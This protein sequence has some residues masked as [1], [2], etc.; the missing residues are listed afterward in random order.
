MT[1]EFEGFYFGPEAVV[2]FVLLPVTTTREFTPGARMAFLKRFDE[3]LA[4]YEVICY[5]EK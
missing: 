1:A 2:Q 5:I 3:I 4:D